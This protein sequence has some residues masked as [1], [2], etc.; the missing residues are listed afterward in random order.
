MARKRNLLLAFDAF[1]TLF[2]PKRSVFAQYGE[3]AR[4][5]GVTCP[6][7]AE[8]G[9]SFKSAFKAETAQHPNYGKAIGMGASTWW[10]NASFPAMI[11]TRF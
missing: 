4:R 10:A 2:T 6:S 8:L 1:G 11:H 3:I 9:T 7:E 5:H